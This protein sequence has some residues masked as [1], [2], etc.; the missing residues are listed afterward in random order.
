M[1]SALS[2]GTAKRIIEDGLFQTRDRLTVTD[3]ASH[4]IPGCGTDDA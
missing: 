2:V 4:L 3:Q 1:A